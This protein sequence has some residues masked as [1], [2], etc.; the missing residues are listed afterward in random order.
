MNAKPRKRSLSRGQKDSADERKEARTL[1]EE[2][3]NRSMGDARRV[4]R[5]AT[6]GEQ[7]SARV[8]RQ[9]EPSSDSEFEL[10]I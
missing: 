2:G 5:A 8:A 7:R 4:S 1:P 3:R 10:P 6:R 9:H